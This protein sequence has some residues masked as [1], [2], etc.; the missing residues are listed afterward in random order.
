[1]IRAVRSRIFASVRCTTLPRSLGNAPGSMMAN[2]R[3]NTFAA[4]HENQAQDEE[5]EHEISSKITRLVEKALEH[6]PIRKS[7]SNRTMIEDILK[8]VVGVMLP[9]ITEAVQKAVAGHS[10]GIKKV[11]SVLRKQDF[12]IDELE[13][14]SRRDNVVIRGIPEEEGEDTN[15]TI[16][17][18]G[19]AIGVNIEDIDISV[20][21]RF[22][23]SQ[24]GKPR[25]IVVKF[26]RRDTRTKVMQAKKNLRGSS[27]YKGVF[28]DEQ[29]TPLRAKLFSLVKNDADTERVWTVDGKICC[30]RRGRLAGSVT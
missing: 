6:V 27:E 16:K 28:I 23:R 15:E 3:G 20:S 2:V 11:E 10:C 19:E 13:Q 22:G 30:I 7:S 17:K 25:P 14:Y 12:R 18:V 24:N 8:G 4:L 9:L 5:I 1:M 29:L 26:V 21:H